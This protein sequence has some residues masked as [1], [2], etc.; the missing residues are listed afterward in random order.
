MG[1]Q[2]RYLVA[3]GLLI[4]GSLGRAQSLTE[5][6]KQEKERQARQRAVA[7]GPAKVTRAKSRAIRRR[8]APP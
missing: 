8:K 6:A 2:R 7:G 5:L 4:L 1:K 3:V